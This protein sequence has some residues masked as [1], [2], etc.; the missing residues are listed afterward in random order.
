[1]SLF[2]KPPFTSLDEFEL[3]GKHFIIN[4]EK[5]NKILNNFTDINEQFVYNRYYSLNYVINY[6]NGNESDG[7]FFDKLIDQYRQIVKYR[8]QHENYPVEI[9]QN[10]IYLVNLI[11]NEKVET[12]LLG[13]TPENIQYVANE[14][15]ENLNGLIHFLIRFVTLGKDD[16]ERENLN[17]KIHNNIIKKTT[18]EEFKYLLKN[19]FLKSI[20][21]IE[22]E[23][24][25]EEEEGEGGGG[26][27]N[28]KKSKKSRKSN[29]S[30]KNKK[31]RKH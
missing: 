28:K 3:D 2:K 23:E 18:D 12:M 22:G 14:K 5:I 11:K 17:D 26:K 16:N 24:E 30:K 15:W 31:S 7:I 20:I 25:G 13:Y 6:Q 19:D 27:R 4:I 1:M 9:E 10:F 21:R 29:K 8:M